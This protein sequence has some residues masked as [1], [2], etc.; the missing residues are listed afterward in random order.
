MQFCFFGYII[1]TFLKAYKIDSNGRLLAIGLATLFIAA[2]TNPLLISPV[3]FLMM[4]ITRAYVTVS[5]KELLV[6]RKQINKY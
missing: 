1:L 6:L 5:A 2:G 3:F 4:V